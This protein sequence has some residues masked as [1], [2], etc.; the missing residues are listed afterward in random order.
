MCCLPYRSIKGT[1]ELENPDDP[2]NELTTEEIKIVIKELEGL[3]KK[4]DVYRR[5]GNSFS[6]NYTEW[7]DARNCIVEK[8]KKQIG[9]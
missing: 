8:L 9:E 3:M 2:N 5:G 7:M 1:I 4:M 6:F